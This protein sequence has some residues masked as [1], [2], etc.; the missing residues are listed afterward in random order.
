MFLEYTLSVN[1]LV[2]G[3]AANSSDTTSP[4]RVLTPT[5]GSE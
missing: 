4:I 1:E 2:Y 5:R 3:G